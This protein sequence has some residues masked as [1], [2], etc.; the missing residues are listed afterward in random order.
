MINGRVVATKEVI[1]GLANELNA[2]RLIFESWR[3]RSRRISG[4]SHLR[5]L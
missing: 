4:K 2:T 3:V 1:A 5:T